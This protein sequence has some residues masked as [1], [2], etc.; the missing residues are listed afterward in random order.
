MPLELTYLGQDWLW[1]GDLFSMT[2]STG[3][4][5]RDSEQARVYVDSLGE[6]WVDIRRIPED[7]S[8]HT[9]RIEAYR[10]YLTGAGIEHTLR[11]RGFNNKQIAPYTDRVRQKR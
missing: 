2:R 4:H 9:E 1:S 7:G 6:T 8:F 3:P 5:W 11:L 10:S